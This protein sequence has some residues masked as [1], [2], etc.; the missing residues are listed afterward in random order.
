MGHA[1]DR[2]LELA[3]LREACVDTLMRR[4]PATQLQ[5]ES[6]LRLR[7]LAYGFMARERSP[8]PECDWVKELDKISARYDG[9]EVCVAV[10]ITKA[11][12][13]A[14]M[15]PANI[16]TS[17]PVSAVC[18]GGVR[19][20]L[21]S[22][23][24]AR[25][26]EAEEPDELP[27]AA[28]S[29]AEGEEESVV[30][31]LVDIGLLDFVNENEVWK[32]RQRYVESG[33]FGVE[34]PGE[35]V[36]IDDG[37][38]KLRL[39]FSLRPSN[40]LQRMIFGDLD[41]L[42]TS[43]QWSAMQLEE[44]QILLMSSSDRQCFFY[45]FSLDECWA[46]AMTLKGRWPREWFAHVPAHIQ[47]TKVRLAVRGVPMGWLSTVGVCQ[48]VHRNLLRFTFAANYPL[49]VRELQRVLQEKQR[50]HLDWSREIRRDRPMSDLHV[51]HALQFPDLHRQ[52]GRV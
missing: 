16:V 24:N 8:C 48:H 9:V 46:K 38:V 2:G 19:E 12:I 44:F 3:F 31:C 26:P 1:L 50:E 45:I 17:I 36:S 6:S 43:A 29:F 27:S 42:P 37:R 34:K 28:L 30:K 5:A 40:A 39:I 49:A 22:P 51:R 52:S 41:Q 14:A 13:A 7:K 11:Q 18:S 32:H 47:G 35:V 15:P 21:R 4:G 33:I 20:A 23:E 25:L 10:P